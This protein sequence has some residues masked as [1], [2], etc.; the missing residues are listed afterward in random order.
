M[1]RRFI[2]IVGLFFINILVTKGQDLKTFWT[3]ADAFLETY[4]QKGSVQYKV[5]EKEPQALDDLVKTIGTIDISQASKTEQKAFYIN[6]YNLLVIQGV[7]QH[8][9]VASPNEVIDFWEGIEYT[10]ANKQYVLDALKA[11][12]LAEYADA[13]LHFVLVNGTASAAPIADFAYR[14]AELDNQLDQQ[15]IAAVNSNKFIQW[16]KTYNV[17]ILPRMFKRYAKDFGSSVVTYIN[18]YR[19]QKMADD[20]QIKYANE[21]WGLNDYYENIEFVLASKRKKTHSPAYFITL[22]KNSLELILFNSLFT[23]T[24][25]DATLGTRS[26]YYNGFFSA[27]YGITGRLD[28]GINFLLRS[29]R[30]RDPY[31]SSPFRVFEFE[32]NVPSRSRTSTAYADWGVSH[33]GFQV[34]FAPFKKISLT[35]EQGFLFPIQGLPTDNTVDNSFYNITQAYYIHMFSSKLQLMLVFT[36]WQ[37]FR[38]NGEFNIQPPMLRGF[39]NY[40]VT[41]RVSLFATSM[42]FVEW[43]VGVRVMLT[44]K[45][46]IQGMYSYFLPIP[47]VQELF[48]GGSSSI[49]TYNMGLRYR[50]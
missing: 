50:F 37:P 45:F 24:Y 13:R 2:Y 33:I 44:P 20:V 30:E 6:A 17:V 5:L 22:P 1:K 27:N 29:S 25:G 47:G 21:D 18:E 36:Y 8:F 14:P 15:V 40:F 7:V 12:I 26:S 39:L 10:V 31:S 23:V 49:M 19:V 32:R 16:D 48:S 38:F 46:E 41:P 4:A 43:G 9:P 35:L 11:F 3:T 34:R 28:V 42:Y